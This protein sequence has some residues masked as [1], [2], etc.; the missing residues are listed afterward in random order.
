M[1]GKIYVNIF[2]FIKK[3]KSE[4]VVNVKIKYFDNLKLLCYPVKFVVIIYCASI[5][6]VMSTTSFK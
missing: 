6:Q 4:L 1:A 5:H 2:S 3:Q